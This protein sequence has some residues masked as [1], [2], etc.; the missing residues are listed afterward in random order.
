MAEF[1]D[2]DEATGPTGSGSS[3]FVDPDESNVPAGPLSWKQAAQYAY[4]NVP[5]DYGKFL[6]ATGHAI[7]HPIETAQGMYRIASGSGQELEDVYRQ[8]MGLPAL[9][10][11]V[12]E[13]EFNAF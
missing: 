4:Q 9:A 7:V 6:A 8:K 11:G 13:P 10:P 5:S 2:P 12:N 1:V 3:K